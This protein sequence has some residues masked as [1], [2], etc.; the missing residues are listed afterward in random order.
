[1]ELDVFE[2]A[3]FGSDDEFL[4]CAVSWLEG[5]IEF[6]G[7]LWGT[8]AAR[9][10]G[11]G[12]V[13]VHGRPSDMARDYARIAASD[14]VCRHAVSTPEQVHTLAAGTVCPAG[15]PALAFWHGY[16]AREL[17]V[18][19]KPDRHGK[20]SG[21]LSVMR[22]DAVPFD[23]VAR[24]AMRHAAQAI[25]TA[26]QVRQAKAARTLAIAP[27]APFPPAEPLTGRELAVAHAYADGRPVKEVARLLGVSASTVQCHLARVYRKMGVHSKMALR[28]VLPDR[29]GHARV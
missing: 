4:D 24:Q 29:R 2:A 27:A 23:L 6:D 8:C 10:A 1:M 16:D 7:L 28:K 9:D 13:R 5:E 17:M 3:L 14:P 11:P 26:Q 22:A 12:D 15:S 21:W 18:F 25:L 19:A 20:A